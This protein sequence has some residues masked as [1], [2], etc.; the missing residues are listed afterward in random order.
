[1]FLFNYYFKALFCVM[2]ATV[3]G[4]YTTPA[5]QNPLFIISSTKVY[6]KPG[7]NENAIGIYARGGFAKEIKKLSNGWSLV[8]VENGDTGFL[9]SKFLTN[10]LN[11]NDKFE[12]DPKDFV[13]PDDENAAYGSPHLFVIGAAV[14]GR[15]IFAKNKPVV[16]I[17][18]TNQP[19]SV[20]YLPYNNDGLVNVEGGYYEPEKMIYIPKK[21]LGKKLNFDASINE[22]NGT[23]NTQL[24][25]QLAERIYEMSWLENQANNLKGVQLFRRYAQETN[26]LKLYNETAFEEFLLI[27]TRQQLEF[28]AQLKLHQNNP[29]TIIIQGKKMPFFLSD[30]NI[31]EI[32]LS[33]KIIKNSGNN[34]YPECG[35][36]VSA[37]YVYDNF[38]IYKSFNDKLNY[39]PEAYFKNNEIAL[40]IAGYQIDSSTTEEAFVKKMGSILQFSWFDAPHIYTINDPDAAAYVFYFKEGKIVK[41][42][43][44][45]YC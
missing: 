42:E 8:I 45:F 11:A 3:L 21:F 38:K 28:E 34:N 22:F 20:S 16:K 12:K 17:Y 5:Q 32:T 36:E 6:S 2:A 7:I 31:N 37:E 1:M 29:A 4:C 26:N 44:F 43:Y 19:V 9:P 13:L 40:N 41:M 35:I 18:R 14:K 24:K 23:S 39:I 10:I 30:S 25:K 15:A 27:H 33:Q